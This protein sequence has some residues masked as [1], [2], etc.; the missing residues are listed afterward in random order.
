MPKTYISIPEAPEYESGY[1]QAI[2]AGNT[3]YVHGT[4]GF[5]VV[6]GEYSSTVRAQARQA[7]LVT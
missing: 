7:L 4:T 1:S 6:R 2:K 3:V 5:N